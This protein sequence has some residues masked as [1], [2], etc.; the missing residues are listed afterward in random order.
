MDKPEAVSAEDFI[1]IWTRSR[2][3]R[4]AAAALGVSSAAAGTR[5]AKMRAQGIPLKR[6]SRGASVGTHDIEE[7]RRLA[8]ELNKK[9]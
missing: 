2:T 1:R 3:R 6:F 7:L 9:E 4:E 5:A 8:D